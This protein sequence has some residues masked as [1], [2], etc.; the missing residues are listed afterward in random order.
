M[1]ISG[2]RFWRP[3]SKQATR[4]TGGYQPPT[5]TRSAPQSC[6]RR[7]TTS[8]RWAGRIGCAAIHTPWSAA[9]AD[10][11]ARR[12]RD[13]TS[14]WARAAT[15]RVRPSASTT[16]G[17]SKSSA[18]PST[19]SRRRS[20]WGPSRPLRAQLQK[21]GLCACD[22]CKGTQKR[23]GDGGAVQGVCARRRATAGKPKANPRTLR[24]RLRRAASVAPQWGERPTG[25]IGGRLNVVPIIGIELMTY[26]LQGGCTF[27]TTGPLPKQCEA[28]QLSVV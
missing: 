14:C 24:N 17:R 10:G 12:R 23:A 9:A 16:W 20:N 5:S 11:R 2:T 27:S 15:G 21:A 26:R 1:R 4:S 8:S 19:P 3:L 28:R 7:Q 6:W 22:V 25:R 13:A 18:S